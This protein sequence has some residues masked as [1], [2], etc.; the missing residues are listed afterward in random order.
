MFR[1]D[2][3]DRHFSLIGRMAKTLGIDPAE[4]MA[5]GHIAPETWRG[6]VLNC[7]GCDAAG[8]CDAWLGA[9]EDGASA[10]PDYCR[11]ADLFARLGQA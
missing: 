5:A 3:L 8:K 6:A 4:K 1:L 2:R 10:T 11:N 9:H 7:S